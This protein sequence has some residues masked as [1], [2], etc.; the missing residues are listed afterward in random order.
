M[1]QGSHF[2]ATPSQAADQ[3]NTCADT[4]KNIYAHTTTQ[5][6]IEHTHPETSQLANSHLKASDQK[7][8]LATM[9][10]HNN[11][12]HDHTPI[13]RIATQR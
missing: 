7:S 1:D 2:T 9:Q 10:Q 13:D 5:G 8:Q 4:Q 3:Q 6:R 12:N 11:T